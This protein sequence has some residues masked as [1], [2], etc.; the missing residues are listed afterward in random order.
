MASNP[1]MTLIIA[2][3]AED[4]GCWSRL[5]ARIGREGTHV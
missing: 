3:L 4:E 5:V 1:P 2:C